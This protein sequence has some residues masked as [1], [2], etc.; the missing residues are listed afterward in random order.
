MSSNLDTSQLASNQV[1]DRQIEDESWRETPR[2]RYRVRHPIYA[3][4]ASIHLI[5]RN[6]QWLLGAEAVVT[7]MLGLAGLIGVYSE[8][9]PTMSGS[10]SPGSS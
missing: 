4:S 10:R 3:G 5:W 1:D 6:V 2:G 9:H 7:G 8:W